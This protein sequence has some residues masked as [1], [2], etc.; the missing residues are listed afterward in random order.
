MG[1][2]GGDSELEDLH[3]CPIGELVR[4]PTV[5]V[6]SF[7]LAH[8]VATLTTDD[9]EATTKPLFTQRAGQRCIRYFKPLP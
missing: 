5:E 6:Q 1:A 9:S 2:L 3:W 7:M 4:L 8:A